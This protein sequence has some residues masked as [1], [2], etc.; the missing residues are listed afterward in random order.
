MRRRNCFLY[1]LSDLVYCH[2]GINKRIFRFKKS[3][4]EVYKIVN[5]GKRKC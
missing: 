3:W 2:K 1:R 4:D 5:S